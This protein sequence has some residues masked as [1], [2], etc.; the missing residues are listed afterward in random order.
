MTLGYIP[1][2]PYVRE[3]GG[4]SWT[5]MVK[6]AVK[7]APCAV[8]VYFTDFQ[9]PEEVSQTTSGV[10]DRTPV[11]LENLSPFGR[12]VGLIVYELLL[13]LLSVGFAVTGLLTVSKSCAFW[14][15]RYVSPVAVDTTSTSISV[16]VLPPLFVAVTVYVCNAVTTVGVPVMYPS[17]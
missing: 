8:T 6:V 7:A 9:A 13:P 17:A 16:V 1:V 4:V 14:L 12:S 5:P 15:P 11:L 10:P 3:V 2:T